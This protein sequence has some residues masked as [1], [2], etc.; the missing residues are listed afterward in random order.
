MAARCSGA[1]CSPAFSSSRAVQTSQTRI[2]ASA[3]GLR[4]RRPALGVH[5]RRRRLAERRDRRRPA[6]ARQHHA[7]QHPSGQ[8]LDPRQALRAPPRS[9]GR[10]SAPAPRAWP[11]SRRAS[12]ASSPSVSIAAC[13]TQRITRRPVRSGCQPGPAPCP[14]R[15]APVQHRRL[16]P[17]PRRAATPSA[18]E[19]VE[20]AAILPRRLEPRRR[21][22]P[23]P[24]SSACPRATRSPAPASRPAPARRPRSASPKN[25][26]SGSAS[27][28]AGRRAEPRAPRPIAGSAAPPDGGRSRR[29][30]PSGSVR[31]GSSGARRV[32]CQ[33]LVGR[34]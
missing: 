31:F 9:P 24:R 18:A 23:R 33:R 28:T 21:A 8:R 11:R 5:R 19:I 15:R 32:R 13:A 30:R 17:A 20:P 6:H 16:R 7:G 3:S 34:P 25:S 12:A 26:G 1:A 22:A 10:D 14:Y 2:S 29:G 27:A 4:E